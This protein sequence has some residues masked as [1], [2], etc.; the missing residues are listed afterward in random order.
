MKT[1]SKENEI[2]VGIDTSKDKLDIYIRPLG[3]YFVVENNQQGVKEAIRRIKPHKPTRVVIE[4]T[5]RM[6]LLFACEAQEAGLPVVI[7]NPLAIHNFASAIG[8]FAKTDKQDAKVIA[9]YGE[10]LKPRLTEIKPKI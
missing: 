3:E 4:A 10:V 1:L 8:Q 7:A 5:G 2:N 9:H 6:E